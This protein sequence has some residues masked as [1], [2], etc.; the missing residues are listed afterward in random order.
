MRTTA[1]NRRLHVLL[2][3]IREGTLVPRPEFQRR[4]VWSNK[5]KIAFLQTVLMEY[6]FP[7]VYIAAGELNPE[8]G[9]ATEMLVDGQQRLSTLHQYFVGSEEL[10][11]GDDV[12][13]YAELP[14]E[15]K[16]RFLEYDVVIRDLG[17]L[18][19][20]DIK[21]V[22]KRINSTDYALN[23]MEVHNA[24]FEGAFK[25]FGEEIA[26]HEFFERHRIFSTTDIKRMQDLRL[27]LIIVITIMSTYFNRD[28]ELES[29]LERYND[30]FEQAEE[31]RTQLTSAFAF[32]EGCGFSPRNR[33]WKKADI[34][35]LVVEL[36]RAIYHNRLD[37]DPKNVGSGLSAFYDEVD[38]SQGASDDAFVADYYK[39]ALQATNDRGSRI[40][41][42]KIIAGL[43]GQMAQQRVLAGA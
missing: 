17:N 23:A 28:D 19:I 32:I 35:T 31:I 7:E 18:S 9:D 5:H 4:L 30:E 1:T 25:K 29:Y 42:G 16:L 37:L 8:T 39:A 21:E 33:V 15:K 41:R 2:T 36:Q 3:A 12:P 27:V 24:R 40:T 43:L 20:P 22:F 26:D 11:L 34:F 13:R 10:R 6:P 38:R 14:Q